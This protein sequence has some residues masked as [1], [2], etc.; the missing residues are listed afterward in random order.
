MF[1]FEACHN[2]QAIWK[3]LFPLPHMKKDNFLLIL[4]HHSLICLNVIESIMFCIL[5]RKTMVC[6]NNENTQ[7]AENILLPNRS[8]QQNNL[9]IPII[10]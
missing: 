1:H 3:S 5:F 2:L 8:M 9:E 4:F 10:E 7:N 6:Y